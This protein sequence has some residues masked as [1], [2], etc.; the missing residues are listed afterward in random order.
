MRFFSSKRTRQTAVGGNELTPL[1]EGVDDNKY[2]AA[3][4]NAAVVDK[5]S[6]AYDRHLFGEREIPA[7]P[8]EKAVDQ[9]LELMSLRLGQKFI[10][11]ISR[12]RKTLINATAKRDRLNLKQGVYERKVEKFRLQLAE[13]RSILD[14]SKTGAHGLFWPGHASDFLGRPSAVIKLITKPAIFV[15]VGFVDLAIIFLSFQNL[16]FPVVESFFLTI[17]AV[18]AQLAFPHLAGGRIR[19]LIRQAPGATRR[20]WS[21]AI[22]ATVMLGIW[23]LF[24]YTIAFIR[25]KFI[26]DEYGREGLVPPPTLVLVFFAISVVLIITLGGWLFFLSVRENEHE[27]GAL[28]LSLS[29]HNMDLATLRLEKRVS[30]LDQRASIANESLN[31]FLEEQENALKAS[32]FSLGEA[33]KAVYRRALINQEGDPEFTSSYFG[34]SK[35]SDR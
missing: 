23:L 33:A 3:S 10:R 7:M 11:H 4:A 13:Q 27:V 31:A 12:A 21:L 2:L 20:R 5:D 35:D 18:G 25:Q 26:L 9:H 30:K 6:G 17:P 32:R 24:V 14:G 34:T 16:T 22:E 1:P 8:Y 28:R 29:L 15:L 19:L